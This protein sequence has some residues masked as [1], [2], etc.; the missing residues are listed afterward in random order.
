MAPKKVA[1][2][3][4]AAGST[5]ASSPSATAVATAVRLPGSSCFAPVIDY[6]IWLCDFPEDS[7]MV[8]FFQEQGWTKL[9]YVTTI[10]I[11]EVKDFYTVKDD[12][13]T[14]EAKPMLI[15]VRLF[16]GFLLFYKRKSREAGIF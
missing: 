12:G 6:I 13:M 3:I 2:S 9:I 8:K 16:K 11:D 1:A 5:A 15:H 7:T 10:G 14:F 4:T